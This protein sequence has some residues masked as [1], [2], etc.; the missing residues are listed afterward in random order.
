VTGDDDDGDDD[1]DDGDDDGDDGDDD[2]DDDDNDDEDDD[3]DDD[4]DDDDDDGSAKNLRYGGTN[5]ARNSKS[6]L[7]GF[8]VSIPRMIRAAITW[9][10]KFKIIHPLADFWIHRRGRAPERTKF[11]DLS[12][13]ANAF[14]LAFRARA[15]RC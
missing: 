5:S 1:G 6:Y 11:L 10:C 12:R 15:R 8:S 2:V 13:A 3:F 4:D 7:S 9:G 14:S